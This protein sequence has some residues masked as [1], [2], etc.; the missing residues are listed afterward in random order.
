MAASE[1][2]A[3]VDQSAVDRVKTLML[4]MINALRAD[5]SQLEE[6]EANL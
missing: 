1:E 2:D 6:I 5:I 4:D 3:F